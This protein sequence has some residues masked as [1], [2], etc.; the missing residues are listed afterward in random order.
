MYVCVCVRPVWVCVCGYRSFRTESN[1]TYF[2]TTKKSNHI[3]CISQIDLLWYKITCHELTCYEMTGMRV[4]VCVYADL[5]YQQKSQF[6][7]TNQ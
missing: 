3:V 5:S 4:Y 6:I 7:T 2:V 1:R